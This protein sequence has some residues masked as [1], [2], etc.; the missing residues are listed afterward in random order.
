MD[1]FKE[2]IPGKGSFDGDIMVALP[3]GWYPLFHHP[4]Q[5][6]FWESRCRFIAVYG[7]RGSG[8]TEIARRKLVLRL[9]DPQPN[10]PEPMYFYAAPTREQAKRI[11]WKKFLRLIPEAWISDINKSELII[12]TVF[13]TSLHICGMNK[14]ERIEGDQWA[15]GI[16]DEA[17]DHISGAYTNSILPA[18]STYDG[19]CW[20]IGVPKRSGPSSREFKSFCSECRSSG[21]DDR[22]C[23][24]WPSTGIVKADVLSAAM[25][26][27]DPKDYREQMLAEW[28]TSGGGVYYCFD[29]AYNVRPCHY[30]KTKPV[31]VSSD[32]NVDPMA[33]TFMQRRGKEH[34][35]AIDELHLEDANTRMAL[36]RTKERFAYHEG[37]FEFHGDATSKARKTSAASS[38]YDQ[39]LEDPWFIQKGRTVHYPDANPSIEDR[40]ARVNAMLESAGGERRFFIDPKCEH[41][42]EDLVQCGFKP[43][44]RQMD[45][46][47]PKRGHAADSAG[48]SIFDLFP[49]DVPFDYDSEGGIHMES[50]AEVV[51]YA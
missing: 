49:I 40:W 41:L 36:R 27:M 20:R 10:N 34:I 17:C 18:L 7:G 31:I 44:T 6:Q 43:G 3:L 28:Q 26:Q 5:D 39:I 12:E 8:K 30:D 13:G 1:E 19:F 24:N 50:L 21:S 2:A 16:I 11:A 47:D 14:P 15:G 46:S 48:Y 4:I 29:E 22:I 45:T 42:R 32:F 37:G 33:W 51:N 38:D 35:E 23:F 25:S 9:A